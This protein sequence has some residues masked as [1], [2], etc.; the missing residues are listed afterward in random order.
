MKG[1]HGAAFNPTDIPS[2][3]SPTL[4]LHREGLPN[5][6]AS[7]EQ[8]QKI[9]L[10]F[11]HFHLEDK[12][13]LIWAGIVMEGEKPTLKYVYSKRIKKDKRGNPNQIRL[14][15]L[16]ELMDYAFCYKCQIIEY[17]IS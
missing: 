16:F 7:W 14:C 8:F 6:E 2:Q 9:A 12:V 17:I 10:H 1:A 15:T 5:L 3:I 4:E 11:P 13:S